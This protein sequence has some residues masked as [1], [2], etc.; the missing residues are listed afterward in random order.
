MQNWLNDNTHL[1]H[2]FSCGLLSYCAV[3]SRFQS[4]AKRLELTADWQVKQ[5]NSIP[6]NNNWAETCI[7][8][9]NQRLE[10]RFFQRSPHGANKM[11]IVVS[12]RYDLLTFFKA[13]LQL[14][15]ST[16]NAGQLQRPRQHLFISKPLWLMQSFQHIQLSFSM[17]IRELMLKNRRGVTV[18]TTHPVLQI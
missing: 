1:I 2:I 15:S 13:E 7:R 6:E 9:T 14:P 5:S 3:F 10:R 17:K 8:R 11:G 12:S 16:T 4:I 18:I